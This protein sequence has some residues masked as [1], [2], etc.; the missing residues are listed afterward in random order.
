MKIKRF[1]LTEDK[2]MTSN[3]PDIIPYGEFRKGSNTY[4]G[5]VNSMMQWLRAYKLEGQDDNITAPYQKFLEETKIDPLAFS[6]FLQDKNKKN[7]VQF[8]IEIEGE[9]IIFSNLERSNQEDTY[10]E[11]KIYKKKKYTIVI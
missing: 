5:L 7:L 9:N 1:K 8:D 2:I 6:Q 3:Q 11:E 10:L 4:G